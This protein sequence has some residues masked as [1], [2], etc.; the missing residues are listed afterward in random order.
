M[1]PRRSSRARATQPPPPSTAMRHTNSSSS[2]NSLNRVDRATRSN[3][4]I[5]PPGRSAARRSQ[6]I[7]DADAGSK[8][9]LPHTRQRQRGRDDVENNDPPLTGDEYDEEEGD[10]EEITRCIC[11]HQDYPGLPP[12]SRDLADRSSLKAG[13]KDEPAQNDPAPESDLLAEDPGSLFIQ[14]DLCKVWQHGGC[15]GIME[16]ALSPDE[17]F[18]ERCRK[19]LHKIIVGAHG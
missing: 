12:T 10:E 15:V 19:D 18:C 5:T 13:A 4:K 6:S 17:Y 1:N 16:E 9:D 11:G 2:H 7:D 3:N 8:N 14:C